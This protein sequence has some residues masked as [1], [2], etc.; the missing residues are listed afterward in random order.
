MV[1]IGPLITEMQDVGENVCSILYYI[2]LFEEHEQYK[3]KTFFSK[4]VLF[5]DFKF[6]YQLLSKL[7][8]W[9]KS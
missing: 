1:Q 7:I 5:F 2:H 8:H 9:V 6:G 3:K 4:T